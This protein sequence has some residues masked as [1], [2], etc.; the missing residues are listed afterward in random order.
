ML[1]LLTLSGIAAMQGSTLQERMAGN[2]RDAEQ[3]FLAAEAA[4]RNGEIFVLQT[5]DTDYSTAGTNGLYDVTAST[6]LPVDWKDSNTLW[7]TGDT[8]GSSTAGDPHYLIEKL[9]EG[10]VWRMVI[11]VKAAEG[12]VVELAAHI[13]GYDRS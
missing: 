2:G 4:L 8:M 13:A 9:P 10:G 6:A 12:A 7:R 1:V 3:A 11:E 5:Q